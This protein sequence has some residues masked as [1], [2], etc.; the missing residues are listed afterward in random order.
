M[1]KVSKY[2]HTVIMTVLN[3]NYSIDIYSLFSSLIN[4]ELLA[5]TLQVLSVVTTRSIC[6]FYHVCFLS[7]LVEAADASANVGTYLPDHTEV[8][9]CSYFYSD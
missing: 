7:V 2:V 6:C 8:I 1:H 3:V 4:D 5:V 9:N